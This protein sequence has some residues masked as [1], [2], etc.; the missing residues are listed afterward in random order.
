MAG[1]GFAPKSSDSRRNK[2]APVRGEW[3]DLPDGGLPVP[4]LPQP[5]PRGG[6]GEPAVRDWTRW[7]SSPMVHMWDATDHGTVEMLLGMVHQW[8]DEP[9][10]SL[11]T[12]IRQIKDSL[13]LTPKGRQ[14]RRW[15]LPEL[16]FDNTDRAGHEASGLRDRKKAAL[17]VLEGGA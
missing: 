9:T 15:R 4:E 12:E 3:I 10:A 7:W 11:A 17:K 1:T 8:Y 6:W 2:T 14:D 13:G 16:S 5:A